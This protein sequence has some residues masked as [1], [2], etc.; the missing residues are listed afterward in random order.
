MP[1]DPRPDGRSKAHITTADR[2]LAFRIAGAVSELLEPAPDAQTIF[3]DA[4]GWTVE[5]YFSGP[6]DPIE[7]RGRL[8]A[9]T[10]VEVPAVG[11][12]TV[13]DENWVAVSQAALPPVRAG[14]FLVHG[15]HDRSA[16]ARGPYTLEIDAGEAFGTAHHATTRGCLLAIDR[17][18]NRGALSRV[19]D[20]GCGSGVLALAA[21]RASPRTRVLA[22]D[23]DPVAVA[24]A[25]ANTRRNGLAQRVS[26]SVTSRPTWSYTPGA[27]DLVAANILATP[28]AELAPSIA[29]ALAVGGLV[30]LS[31]L[32][33]R[34][35]RL[36]TARYVALGFRLENRWTDAG[37][38]V[39][40]LR[41][42]GRRKSPRTLEGRVVPDRSIDRPSMRIPVLVPFQR[43][44]FDGSVA[45]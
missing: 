8:A 38:T 27:F 32:L 1:S 13:P 12:A 39:L 37:W 30:V 41:K 9:L 23:N 18:A 33:E 17:I 42:R 31:G 26:V 45:T 2:A 15:S 5:I 10:G 40:E 14:R 3:E 28:L 7:L 4:I 25:R 6:F 43:E 34:E 20:I 11:A 24:V 21:G 36:L 35:A 22:V 19:L 44:L 29:R 16:I